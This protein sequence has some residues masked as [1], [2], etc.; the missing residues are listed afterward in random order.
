MYEEEEKKVLLLE[1]LLSTQRES[2][3][4]RKICKRVKMVEKDKQM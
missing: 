3:F 2:G 4:A 1:Q